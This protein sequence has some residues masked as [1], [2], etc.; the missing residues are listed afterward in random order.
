MVRTSWVLLAFCGKLALGVF[1]DSGVMDWFQDE[2]REV[3][4]YHLSF[5]GS[6]PEYVRGLFVQSGPAR[7]TMGKARVGHAFDGFTKVYR[8]QFH[9]D[10]S[11]KFSANFLQSSFLNASLKKGSIA[12]ALLMG[13]TDPPLPETPR[14][15]LAGHNDNNN[16]KSH[17]IGDLDVILSDTPVMSV[18]TEEFASLDHNIRPRLFAAGI[19]GMPWHDERGITPTTHI[20]PTGVMAHGKVD[21]TSGL[22]TVVACCIA[23]TGPL[24]HDYHI[25]FN[26]DP[27]QPDRRKLLASIQLPRGRPA[28]YMHSMAHTPNHVV[29]VAEPLHNSLTGALSGKPLGE[30]GLYMGDGNTIFQAVSRRDGSVREFEVPPFLFSHIV[31]AWEVGNDIVID[32]IRYEADPERLIFVK[33]FLFK[34]IEDKL[35]RDLWPLARLMR[36]R[37]KSDGTTEF[38]DLL[39]DEFGTMFELIKIDDR[40]HG[41]EYCNFFGMQFH[42]NAYDEE[43]NSTK[44]GPA[45]AYA[46]GKRN[47]CTGERRGYYGPNEYPTEIEF[48]PNPAGTAEDDGVLVGFVFD[49]NTNSS[50]VQVLDAKTMSRIARAELPVRIPLVVHA[51][52]FPEGAPDLMQQMV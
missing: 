23:V 52:F 17:R 11:V 32:L 45:M 15:A 2:L 47:I 30:G 42:S 22:F 44:V 13:R 24:Q 21:P 51:A 28:S 48:I 18:F 37:L 12:L 46:I 10:G 3:S 8:L 34:N 25:V 27:K 40:K 31:H 29:L 1:N 35:T 26:I 4:N 20:C 36:F 14:I 33:Q 9:D 41:Q 19:P 7:Y 50:F 16:I 39:P 38:R 49:A 43:W 6:V 5:N